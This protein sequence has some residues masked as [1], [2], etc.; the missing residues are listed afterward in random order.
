LL[1]GGSGDGLFGP[2]LACDENAD[3][4]DHLCRRGCSLGQEDVSV[5][6]AVEGVDGAGDDH[7]RQAGME[8]LGAADEFVAVHLRHEEI[9]EQQVERAGEG[10]LHELESLL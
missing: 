6:G 4:L 9:T 3:A 8:L 10:L 7:C 2:T 1:R 5:D